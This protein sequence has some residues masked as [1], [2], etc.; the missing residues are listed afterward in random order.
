MQA[1]GDQLLLCGEIDPSGLPGE[2]AGP[3]TLTRSK[4]SKD[5]KDN[6]DN[7]DGKDSKDNKDSKDADVRDRILLSGDVEPN[8]GPPR[9]SVLSPVQ[10]YVSGVWKL[11]IIL[12]IIL[13]DLHTNTTEKPPYCVSQ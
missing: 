6:K 1:F 10:C 12:S 5:N 4:D 2:M 11:G 8:P 13:M 7:K 3:G 9:R